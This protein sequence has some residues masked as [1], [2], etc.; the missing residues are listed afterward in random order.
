M[1]HNGGHWAV[2]QDLFT[3]QTRC[4]VNL[5]TSQT[6]FLP[7]QGNRTFQHCPLGVSTCRAHQPLTGIQ[8]HH[9]CNPCPTFTVSVTQEPHEPELGTPV[10]TAF[11]QPSQAPHA[12]D[13]A[14]L[15]RAAPDLASQ[16]SHS[17][18]SWSEASPGKCHQVLPLLKPLQGPHCSKT[19]SHPIPASRGSPAT[20]A[21]LLQPHGWLPCDFPFHALTSAAGLALPNPHTAPCPGLHETSIKGSLEP[22]SSPVC[23]LK[24]PLFSSSGPCFYLTLSESFCCPAIA[25][26]TT[27]VMRT[28]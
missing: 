26:T 4:G 20:Q 14:G 21:L 16:S 19:P 3:L 2:T 6:Y 11:L 22:A 25:L 15:A 5:G 12:A 24:E 27:V 13:R 8:P 17:L 23:L 9:F 1:R 10:S 28:T 7:S 18:C